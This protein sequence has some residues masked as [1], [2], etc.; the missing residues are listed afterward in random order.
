MQNL[1]WNNEN[2]V[3][4]ANENIVDI[5]K[6][7]TN[8]DTKKNELRKKIEPWLTS[9]FQ[10]EHLSLLLG[11]G[12][13]AAVADLAEILTAKMER[14]NFK[15]YT[16]EISETANKQA[17]EM[18]RGVANFEDDL[19][20]AIELLKGLNIIDSKQAK[21]LQKEI[22]EELS[23]LMMLLLKTEEDFIKS[24]YYEEAMKYL[25]SF[26]ISFSSRTAT[27][28]RL[29]IFTTNYDR[30]VE[31]ACDLAGI[32]IIDRFVGKINP[33]F[34]TNK[35]ELDFHY[36][37][38]G[39]R[40]EPRYVE[41]VIRLTKLHGSL[42]WKMSEKSIMRSC[43]PFGASK[44]H[45]ET[46][47]NPFESLII[48]P[49][50]AKGIDTVYYPYSELFRDFSAAISRPNSVLVT[51]GYGFG[52]SHINRII[53]DMLTIPSSHLVI[54]SYNNADGRIKN[55]FEQV[56]KA[57]VTLLIGNKLGA[58]KELVDL[59]L[60][61]AAI[62]RISIREAR[63]KKDRGVIPSLDNDSMGEGGE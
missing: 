32:Y 14:I 8:Y 50:S 11:S 21:N 13:T 20:V 24:K 42:D 26:L 27:R 44:D 31:L 2:I 4:I 58:L 59:Y 34:R 6:L 37:P 46:L 19:R 9:I 30:F 63:I 38:P 51:Y 7:L 1:N 47:K 61:K 45:S 53:K 55:F 10:S 40:G 15:C 23:S 56:N 48:F 18:D 62:D 29:N 12:L 39:I 52:D 35:M 57:Q 25:K 3:W 28:D 41:G 54:I 36:N 33:L 5:E 17:K 22:N 60:P 49:N 43:L 16:K